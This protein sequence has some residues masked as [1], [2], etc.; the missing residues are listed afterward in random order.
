M[1]E[2]IPVVTPESWNP[3]KVYYV[4]RYLIQSNGAWDYELS[5]YEECKREKAFFGE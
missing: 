5:G 3:K 1:G 2:S 4:K